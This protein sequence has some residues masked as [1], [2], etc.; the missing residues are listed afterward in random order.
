MT[1][2]CLPEF[3]DFAHR[4]AD[5]TGEII[6]RDFRTPLTVTHKPDAS[7][8]TEVDQEAESAIRDMVRARYP[9][10]GVIG[11]EFEAER[12][13]ADYV[14]VVDPLDGT[15]SFITGKPLFGTLIGLLRGGL[16]VLG[17][18]DHPILRERWIGARGHATT[19]NG[20]PARVRACAGLSEAVLFTTDPDTFQ[21]ADGSAF[22]RVREASHMT[23][24]G[25][26]C[27]CYGLL[28]SGLV[29]LIVEVGLGPDDYFPMI[30]LIE[31][32]GG[33]VTDWSG[34]PFTMNS[35]GRIVVAG[36]EAVHAE[37]LILLKG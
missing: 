8:V 25:G 5:R 6:R 7:P 18:I 9:E 27:Y 20:D 14:W 19:V 10:H 37:A 12:P 24:Y 35:D 23:M 2:P 3:I 11:E 4:L 36:D 21:G 31:E 29:D 34:A 33:V 26:D 1:E 28:A 32:A 15:K 17:L 16:P 30:A 13:D 22:R